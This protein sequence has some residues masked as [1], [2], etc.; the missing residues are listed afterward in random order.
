MIGPAIKHHLEKTGRKQCDLAAEWKCEPC[1]ITQLVK[2]KSNPT[3]ATII[4]VAK[5]L[6]ISVAEIVDTAIQMKEELN[7]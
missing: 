5:T 2:P 1:A 6:N 4:K 3:W 7:Q